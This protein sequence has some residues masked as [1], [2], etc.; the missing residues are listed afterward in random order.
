MCHRIGFVPQ[1]MNNQKP[2]VKCTLYL[3][4]QNKLRHNNYTGHYCVIFTSCAISSGGDNSGGSSGGDG[5][6]PDYGGE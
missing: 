5:G 2:C 6:N 4:I 3:M 1:S